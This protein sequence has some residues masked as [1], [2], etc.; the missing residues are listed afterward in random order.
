MSELSNLDQIDI[1]GK[2]VFLR[3]DF[4]VPLIEGKIIS[5]I[6]ILEAIPT[7]KLILSKGAA[8]IIGSHLGRPKGK[9]I[10]ELSIS[11]IAN[12]LKQHLQL[13][14]V[15]VASDV[16]G[17]SAISLSTK[18]LPGDV[19]FVENLRFESGEE[20]NDAEMAK[21][22]A[23]MAD[24]FVNDA[25]SCS[26]RAHSSVLGITSFLPSVAGLSMQ[27]EIDMLNKV[28]KKPIKPVTAIVGGSKISTKLAILEHLIEKV[29]H[30]IIGGAMANTFLFANGYSVGKSLFESDMLETARNILKEAQLKSCSISLPKDAMVAEDLENK[31]GIE[32]V[33]VERV[34]EE[35]MIL[36]IGPR[37]SR[38]ISRVFSQSKTLLWN[39]PLGVF[40]TKPF[41]TG[42]ILAAKS[43]AKLT[44]KGSLISVAG[45]GDTLAALDMAGVMEGFSHVST[46]GGA[47]L[48]WLKGDSLPGIEALIIN[49]S[50]DI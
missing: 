49:R 11:P 23:S 2:K 14:N 44:N 37:T 30:M 16:I 9:I 40:E 29:D 26:H 3:V 35:K 22:L 10:P 12:I 8:V 31:E 48:E 17:E 5:D 45:G 41:D 33:D 4:N 50:K 38:V 27:K 25:F 15:M 1:T 19:M 13:P 28:L 47:F 46:G 6:R 42:T 32:T 18:L 7:I 34:P 36:D 43:V 24:V 39:G 21:V 20:T